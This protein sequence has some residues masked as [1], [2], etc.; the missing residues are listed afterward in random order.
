VALVAVTT[1]VA[2]LDQ[3]SADPR[4]ASWILQEAIVLR[5][6]YLAPYLD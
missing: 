3:A 4:R 5:E 2:L 6:A 1:S